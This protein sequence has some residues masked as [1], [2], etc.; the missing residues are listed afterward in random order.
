MSK[1]TQLAFTL[2]ELLVVISIIALL[3]A[4][5]LPA[6]AKTRTTAI[7][8]QCL[9]QVKQMGLATHTYAFD[10]DG[11]VPPRITWI[12]THPYATLWQ[13]PAVNE[14]S[15]EGQA[16]LIPYL[17]GT[18]ADLAPGPGVV[19]A[20]G[21]EYGPADSTAW[22]TFRCPAYQR[23]YSRSLLWGHL[24]GGTYV[25]DTH[26][27][28]TCGVR[29]P[30]TILHYPD[31]DTQLDQMSPRFPLFCDRQWHYGDIGDV[32]HFMHEVYDG[33]FK[34]SN[35]VRTDGSGDWV[36]AGSDP[37]ENFVLFKRGQFPRHHIR[38]KAE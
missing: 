27:S 10:H 20:N 4:L 38:P 24:G 31:S 15:G 32:R 8:M 2:I 21:R 12:S 35:T 1:T 18:L 36:A 23:I 37:S 25:V 9:S 26:Y 28:Q 29:D 33:R 5:L 11:V 22:N 34:G 14:L 30:E 16:M 13:S 3:I 6:L 17:G 19:R 7:R